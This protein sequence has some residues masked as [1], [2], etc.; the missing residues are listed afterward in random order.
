MSRYVCEQCRAST[1]RTARAALEVLGAE[2]ATEAT[3]H[4]AAEELGH[5]LEVL[6]QTPAPRVDGEVDQRPRPQIEATQG[7]GPCPSSVNQAT[8]DSRSPR[9]LDN[10]SNK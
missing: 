5:A 3:R 9:P 6:H 4:I 1:L 8:R 7:R 2:D 10:Q